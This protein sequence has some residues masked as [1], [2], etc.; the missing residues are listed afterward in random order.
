MI[1]L[2]AICMKIQSYGWSDK[3]KG[4]H[5]FTFTTYTIVALHT[6]RKKKQQP[7]TSPNQVCF[8]TYFSSIFL[9]DI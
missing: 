2:Q 1:H 7:K 9:H 8:I 4:A 5:H 6:H 3:M